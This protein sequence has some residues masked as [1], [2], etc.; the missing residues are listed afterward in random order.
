MP[1][2]LAKV[3]VNTVKIYSPFNCDFWLC[4]QLLDTEQG[5]QVFQYKIIISI[6]WL[7]Q[8]SVYLWSH[9]PRPA[10]AAPSCKIMP[11]LTLKRKI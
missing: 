3:D 10:T 6:W 5:S 7:I 1:Q 4:C 9:S 11:Y 8:Q 2:V